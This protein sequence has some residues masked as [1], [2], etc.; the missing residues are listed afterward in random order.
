MPE[1][2]ANPKSPLAR[3]TVSPQH[4]AANVKVALDEDIGSGDI[5]AALI[6]EDD[7]ASAIIITREEGVV[8]GR[9]WVDAVFASV[10]PNITL[11]WQVEDGQR[12]APNDLLFCAD[13][14]A[15]HL[16]TAERTALNF[17]QLMSGTATACQRLAD[18]VS[19]T[20][21]K[22]LDTRKTIPGLRLAQKYAVTQG[23]CYNHRIGLYDAF[24]VKENHIQACGGIAEAASRARQLAPGKLLEI[25]VEGMGELREA[26]AANCDRIMLDNFTLEQLR[27][28]VDLTAGKIALEASGNVNESTLLDIANTGV[29]YISIGAL[30]KDCKALDLSMRLS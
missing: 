24:L 5:T 20:K 26:L 29:D 12:V 1:N 7:Q 14:S 28:A 21:V 9:A 11:N 3:F 8:C 2:S 16:L 23:S 13:G 19:S 15:R 22:L 27:E 17:L 25:E 18:I 4:I 30:T 6:P 10:D